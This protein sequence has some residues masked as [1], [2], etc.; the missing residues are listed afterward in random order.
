M[1]APAG[2]HTRHPVMFSAPRVRGSWWLLASR[3][4]A[5]PTEQ[6]RR[7]RY[8]DNFVPVL[9]KVSHDL[10]TSPPLSPTRIHCSSTASLPHRCLAR[11]CAAQPLVC[12]QHGATSA[13]AGPPAAALSPACASWGGVHN[14]LPG[15]GRRH[16]PA[17]AAPA[18]AA[19]LWL[20]VRVPQVQGRTPCRLG[21]ACLCVC[22]L[23]DCLLEERFSRAYCPV[24]AVDC[25]LAV[26]SS[27]SA[28]CPL[29]VYTYRAG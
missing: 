7:Y 27:L 9:C 13:A 19:A 3:T 26:A 29:A 17:A 1:R 15:T 8:L 28:S 11:V 21:C 4:L 22:V 14:L 18:A 20:R 24:S 2:L 23:S 25:L 5:M 6:P 10:L 12:A 16:A